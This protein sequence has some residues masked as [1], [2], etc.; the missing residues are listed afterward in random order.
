M[1]V[2]EMFY[3]VN[4][5]LEAWVD[6]SFHERRA[7]SEVVSYSCQNAEDIVSLLKPLMPFQVIKEQI[8]IIYGT[9]DTFYKG[10][11]GALTKNEKDKIVTSMQKIKSILLTMQSMCKALGVDLDSCG[12]DIKLPPNM[13]LSELSE[14]T[15]DLNHIFTQC[16][17]LHSDDEQIQFR[18]VDVGSMWLTFAIIGVGVTTAFY[19]LNNIAAMVDKIMIIRS[20]AAACQQ[21]EELIRQAKLKNDML[22]TIVDAN[23][24]AIKMLT[25][26]V[27]EELA[28]ENGVTSHDDIAH[29][30]GSLS[31]LK[32]WV[33]KGLEVYAAVDAPKEVKAVFPP[34]E[35]QSLSN[36]SIKELKAHE[37]DT[38]E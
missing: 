30:E 8:D 37:N 28:A 12:F 18:G 6:P 14:C 17:L 24:Q 4:K 35:I 2:H 11:P 31:M 33:D 9:H 26:Q 32:E 19:I 38:E 10:K 29:I 34:L 15:K 5:A 16:P 23:K 13:T 1:R 25:R 27:A 20:H 3:L 7:G 22:Q 21:Q 36:F